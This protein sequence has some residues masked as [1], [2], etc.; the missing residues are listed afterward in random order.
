MIGEMRPYSEMK[1]SGL[2][3]LGQVPAHWLFRR[4]K[5]LFTKMDRRPRI[6][7]D[8][9]TCFRDGTVTL[10]KNRRTSG[11]TEALKEIGY[12]GIR[13]GDLVI[14][15][16]DAF[17]GAIGVSDSDGKGTPVYSVCE[18]RPGAS[19]HFYA[20]LL[21]EMSR[22][23]WIQALAKGI[24]ERSTD[25]RYPAFG[26]QVLPLPPVVEQDAIVRFLD[27]VDRRIRRYLR[28]KQKLIKLLEEQKQ[29]II[30]Q[31]VTRGL[32]PNAPLKPSGIPWLGDIPEH[33]DVMALKF[34]ASLQSGLTLGK[35]YGSEPTDSY[36]YLRVANVQHGRV[37][38]RVVKRISVPPRDAAGATLRTGDVLMTEGGDIDK[39]GR[40]CVWHG[41]VPG[42]LHQNH[43]FAVR[44]NQVQLLP[45]FLAGLLVSR[46][47]RAY[48]QLTAKQTTNLAAT[49]STTVKAFPVLVPPVEEQ[50]AILAHVHVRT[51]SLESAI[52]KAH[53]ELKLFGDFQTRLIADVVT[54][55][56]DVRQAAASLPAGDD[57]VGDDA[58]AADDGLNDDGQ[59]DEADQD[60]IPE[61]AEVAE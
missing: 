25:F 14:H 45:D 17:A 58:D 23:Q 54:G 28:A 29:A 21:R 13:R 31:A 42:C 52:S 24:R 60:A 46:H 47:G 26:D 59:P 55:K 49:N 6:E 22:S 36:P 30:H 8:V 1:D 27:H 9:V 56:L 2:P 3:W 10:R 37:D 33:W 12:Q 11:F 53:L 34:C 43:V 35:N 57:T 16:M 4:G 48:F 15:A 38:L 39:L 61:E 50:S 41:E 44:C 51:A 40:G 20:Y 5:W 18:P 19:S 32:N 7:D